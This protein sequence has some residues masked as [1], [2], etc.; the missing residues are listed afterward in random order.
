MP[1]D[2]LASGV[3]LRFEA[4]AVENIPLIKKGDDL[5]QII[6]ERADV[7]DGD[8]IIIASTIVGKA[9]GRTFS[10]EGIIPG[11]EAVEFSKHIRFT[12]TFIQAVLERSREC[13]IPSPVLLVEMKNGHICINAGID[14]SNVEGEMLLELPADPDASA[15]CIGKGIESYTG[16]QISVIITDTNGRAFKRGQTGVAVGVYRIHP[17]K[18][19]RGQKDLFG[20]ELKITEEAVADEIAGTSNLLMGEGNGGCPVVIIRG[21]KLRSNESTSVNEM[22]RTD[23]EDLIKKSLR[24][25][26]DRG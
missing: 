20:K 4:F 11:A 17:L 15:E 6:C 25:L 21:L 2:L 24:Y 16:T 22:Y 1:N 9:E 19:W 8:V 26:R 5:A 14:E 7:L 23:E 12:P 3:I 10:L 18:D 13:L